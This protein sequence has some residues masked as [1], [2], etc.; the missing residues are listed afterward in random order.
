M[1]PPVTD[2]P[3]QFLKLLEERH[4]TIGDV[5]TSLDR[6]GKVSVVAKVLFLPE[7]LIEFVRRQTGRRTA[8]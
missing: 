4:L 6:H 5:E 2:I 1:E 8:R 3:R 7:E